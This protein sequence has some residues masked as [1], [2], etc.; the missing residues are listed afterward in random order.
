MRHA[1][2]AALVSAPLPASGER[3]PQPPF[4]F[5]PAL[6]PQPPPEALPP[7]RHVHPDGIPHDRRT[8]RAPGMAALALAPPGPH[9]REVPAHAVA[10]ALRHAA[11][12]DGRAGEVDEVLGHE[13]VP[14]LGLLLALGRRLERSAGAWPKI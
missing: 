2:S 1:E 11:G 8:G 14:D 13:E 7:R 6:P 4:P 9:P 5:P 12:G 10:A 3:G